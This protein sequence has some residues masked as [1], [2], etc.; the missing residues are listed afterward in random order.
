MFHTPLKTN[1]VYPGQ[2]SKGVIMLE[3]VFRCSKVPYIKVGL[4]DGHYRGRC[5]GMIIQIWWKQHF[6]TYSTCTMKA[7]AVYV[8][9]VVLYEVSKN[10]GLLILASFRGDFRHCPTIWQAHSDSHTKASTFTS[11]TG[12][13][14]HCVVQKPITITNNWTVIYVKCDT[15]KRCGYLFIYRGVLCLHCLYFWD[16]CLQKG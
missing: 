10:D 3:S 9:Y 16:G 7:F 12:C 15:D 11:Y 5:E 4:K 6:M 1:Q 14:V 8:V 13:M 2:E